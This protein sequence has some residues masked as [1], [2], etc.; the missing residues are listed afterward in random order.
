[1]EVCQPTGYRQ[2]Q[3]RHALHRNRVPV[4]VIVQRAVLVVLWH[5]PELSPRAIICRINQM[6]QLSN[7][8]FISSM[9]LGLL[10]WHLCCQQQWIPGCSHAG[11]WWSDKSLL[12]GTTTAHPGRR[13]S[14]RLR[15]LLATC[16]ATPHQTDLFRWS[17]AGRWFEL[18]FSGPAV[19]VLRD[20]NS[21]K[22]NKRCL[23]K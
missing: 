22:T 2:S 5:Q 18:W 20:T 16:R 11:A 17:P 6:T 4:Q 19:E 9:L 10:I 8:T 3:N 15:P 13:R 21:F 14:S 7:N 23:G 12:P 1:M